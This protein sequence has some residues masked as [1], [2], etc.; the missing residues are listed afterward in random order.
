MPKGDNRRTHGLSG[1]IE[2]AVWW[3]MRRRCNSPMVGNYADYGGRGIRVCDRWE[4]SFMA[5][6]SD[7]GSRPS[8][9][10][11][12]DRV[13]ND[14]HYEPGNCRWALRKTQCNNRRHNHRLVLN[15]ISRTCAE[16]SDSTGL[17]IQTILWRVRQGWPVHKCL[18]VRRFDDKVTPEM[19]AAIR[20]EYQRDPAALN[21]H[22]VVKQSDLA[23]K[24]GIS[25][26]LVGNIVR[27][28]C[29]ST[30]AA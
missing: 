20:S 3:S 18:A 16:W 14:G 6:L 4:K 11:S 8:E 27:G 25:R 17:P 19:A 28:E 13:D 26:S 22:G 9:N 12:I 24:Y 23:R 1:T 29:H 15:G 2:Y 21:L 30:R 5:F 10:H 7:M